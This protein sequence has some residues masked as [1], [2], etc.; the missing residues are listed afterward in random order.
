MRDWEWGPMPRA[1]HGE[2]AQIRTRQ[3]VRRMAG[4]INETLSPRRRAGMPPLAKPFT[5]EV[6]FP[7]PVGQDKVRKYATHDAAVTALDKAWA[8]FIDDLQP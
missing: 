7:L 4:I 5:L 1:P 6:Y 2:L 3:G 8:A